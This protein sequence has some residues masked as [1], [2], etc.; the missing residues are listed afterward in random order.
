MGILSFTYSLPTSTVLISSTGK[1]SLNYTVNATSGSP[2]DIESAINDVISH[3]GG[4]VYIPAGDWRVDQKPEGA[5]PIDL[6][7]L[8]SGAWLNIIGTGGNT[9]VV[10][11]N[12]QTLTN[13]PACILRSYTCVN[14]NLTSAIT[15]FGIVGSNTSYP[16]NF[17]YVN[18]QNRHIRI[19]GITI[20]GYVIQESNLTTPGNTGI[21]LSYVDGFLIDHC[22][23]DSNCGSDI[24]AFSSK[25]VISHCII[26]DLYHVV[27]GGIWGY[28]VGVCG[29]F[30]FYINGLGTATW[31]NNI[32]DVI[33]KYD[34]QGI[35]INYSVPV[36]NATPPITTTTNISYNAGPVYVENCLFNY[37]RHA[38]TASQ[39]GYYVLRY[40]QLYNEPVA[41]FDIIDAHGGGPSL[42][43]NAYDTR[44]VEIYNNT[45]NCNQTGTPTGMGIAFR[46]NGGLVFNNTFINCITGI[47]LGNENYD[48]NY[49][50]YPEY[51]NNI[52]IW[53][54]AFINVTGTLTV[55]TANGITAGVNY[56]IDSMGGTQTPTNPAPPKTGYTPYTYPHPLT[57][58]AYP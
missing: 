42:G 14:N 40:C 58:Q 47:T 38:I 8:P 25:G 46:G 43:A 51:C 35:T 2:A 19:S 7:T 57:Y 5:I 55:D 22:A 31:I 32:D 13:V 30:N 3:G 54:N 9:S 17:N 21:G 27:E 26:T 24:G 1:I 52:W 33:G 56:F 49:P 18:S 39:Y 11:Q 44:F 15:T 53:D 36:N 12:G 28:G 48:P 10:T 23:I 6:E 16:S 20:L 4:T 41:A 45:I 34:W 37:T 29:N 50:T